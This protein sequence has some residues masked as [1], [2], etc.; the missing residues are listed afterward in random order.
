MTSS[1][2][3]DSNPGTQNGWVAR[4]SAVDLTFIVETDAG[5]ANGEK[6]DA[7]EAVTTTF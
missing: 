4:V 7:V 6:A 2:V 5:K 1:M 3:G